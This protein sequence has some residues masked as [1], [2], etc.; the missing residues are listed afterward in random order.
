[1][2]KWIILTVWGVI[3]AVFVGLALRWLEHRPGRSSI[4]AG[5]QLLDPALANYPIGAIWTDGVGPQT[6]G[7]TSDKIVEFR[8]LD[9]TE[10]E[11]SGDVSGSIVGN[12]S[13]MFG[14]TGN[15]SSRTYS[16]MKVEHLKILRV[17][18]AAFLDLAAGRIY[19]WEGALVDR[20]S[21][22]CAHG[23]ET[24]AQAHLSEI[25][26]NAK[27]TVSVKD[28]EANLL[29]ADGADLFVAYRLVKLETGPVANLY[30]HDLENAS[31]VD[32]GSEYKI[33]FRI[34]PDAVSSQNKNCKVTVQI[35][36]Y[37]QYEGGAPKVFSIDLDCG[38][39]SGDS[40]L[41]TTV[42]HQNQNLISM[43][44]LSLSPGFG[45]WPKTA[46]VGQAKGHL[47]LERRTLKMTP[48]MPQ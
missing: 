8:S 47:W 48:Y 39:N 30:P 35:E 3:A 5:Y 27:L 38:R 10:F 17:K 28:K 46:G 22:R 21:F 2:K 7:L 32:L 6:L 31:M 1:M 40:Y 41:F 11:Q 34:G 20:F 14:I 36:S 9:R 44:Y 16:D 29:T 25:Q 13:K 19:V 45:V 24:E 42:D 33:K 4:L 37:I 26:P 12:L 23:A 43:E 18:D 15:G